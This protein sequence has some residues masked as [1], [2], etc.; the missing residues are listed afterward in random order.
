MKNYSGTIF[1]LGMS[2][3]VLFSFNSCKAQNSV[4]NKDFKAIR[5]ARKEAKKR[6]KEGWDVPPGSIPMEKLFE[7]AW[8]IESQLDDDG[9]QKFLMATG[10][11]VAG[12]KSAADVAAMTAARNE[13]AAAIQAKVSQLIETKTANDQIDQ[14]IANTLDKT[15]ANSKSLIQA[16]LQ[17]VKTA[18]KIYKQVQDKQNK[19]QNIRV[20]LKLF[21]SQE[22]AFK[23][24]QKAIRQKLEE[25]ADDLGDELDQILNDIG[26]PE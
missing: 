24:A 18:Y 21:Y 10:S 8:T 12:T 19:R 6:R 14:N 11:A 13:L 26:W 9:S 1:A 17:Q 4:K 16:N 2:L 5:L 7:N 3:F 20:E 15:I 23:A 22:E 25:E